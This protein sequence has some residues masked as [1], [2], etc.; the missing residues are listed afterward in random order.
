MIIMGRKK[1]KQEPLEFGAVQIVYNPLVEKE[2]MNIILNFAEREI[3]DELKRGGLEG[4]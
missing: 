3:R 2:W 1:K 4:D